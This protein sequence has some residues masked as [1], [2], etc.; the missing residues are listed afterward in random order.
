MVFTTS[1][2]RLL[3]PHDELSR[4]IIDSGGT[5]DDLHTIL[6][7]LR[8]ARC[9]RS[10]EAES[11]NCGGEQQATPFNGRFVLVRTPS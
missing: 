7:L 9:E 3:D 5:E 8:C 11:I 4:L 6:P 2:A 1:T 10:V